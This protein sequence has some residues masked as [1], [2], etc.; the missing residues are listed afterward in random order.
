MI[1][2]TSA[3]IMNDVL[4]RFDPRPETGMFKTH[5]ITGEQ[6]FIKTIQTPA[7]LAAL[8]RCTFRQAAVDSCNSWK[9]TACHVACD[10][11]KIN[12]HQEV[13]YQ[14]IDHHGCNVNLRDRHNR[15]PLELLIQTKVLRNMPSATQ[16][17]EE[18]LIEKRE[19]ELTRLYKDFATEE[20]AKA[21]IRRK[22]VM[23]DCS[24]RGTDISYKNWECVRLGSILKLS[25]NENWEMYEDPD[26]GNYFY[27]KAPAKRLMGESYQHYSWSKPSFAKKI[28]DQFEAI[29]YL[30]KTRS[31]LLRV[32]NK[33][34]VY[35]CNR[36]SI[37]FYYNTTTQFLTFK[38]PLELS[39][40]E[41]LKNS[42]KCKEWLGF[43]NEWEVVKD[44][45]GVVFYKNQFTDECEWERPLDAVVSTPNEKLCTAYQV[46]HKFMIKL[47]I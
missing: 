9:R 35:R 22:A 17:K 44:K 37:D 26:T 38:T 12:S 15:R 18:I 43:T 10:E 13:I 28:L 33:W 4:T 29:S 25:Y 23:D 5:E 3:E 2:H 39:W 7:D 41:I 45:D 1:P 36:T 24:R 32:H 21:T 40:P 20:R 31:T 19:E 16:A 11:N 46:Y 42:V 8:L 47:S 30:R 6:T 27:T 34:E 14:L